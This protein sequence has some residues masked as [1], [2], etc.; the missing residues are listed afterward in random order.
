MIRNFLAAA[1]LALGTS[2]AA[3]GFGWT[4]NGSANGNNFWR[5]TGNSLNVGQIAINVNNVPYP[6]SGGYSNLVINQHWDMTLAMGNE[7]GG[8]SCNTSDGGSGK[9]YSCQKVWGP[10][11]WDDAINMFNCQGFIF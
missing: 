10:A 5:F 8:Y 1:V 4:C 2:S 7:Q 3:F 9:N 6:M 11:N